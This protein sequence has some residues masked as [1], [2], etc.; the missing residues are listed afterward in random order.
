MAKQFLG[1]V[2]TN[3]FWI[4]F[5]FLKSFRLFR[6]DTLALKSSNNQ[7]ERGVRIAKQIYQVCCLSSPP[8]SKLTCIY[9][10]CQATVREATVML[11]KKAIVNQGPFRYA[12]L[13]ES[14]DAKYFSR[15]L[16]ST[17]AFKSSVSRVILVATHRRCRG[18]PSFCSAPLVDVDRSAAWCCARRTNRPTAILS[19]VGCVSHRM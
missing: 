1:C 8:N 4:L 6:Y 14:A 15:P 12:F 2:K 13:S 11:E 5:L 7:L 16:V 17:V 19:L 3:H 9:N 18:W 10:R